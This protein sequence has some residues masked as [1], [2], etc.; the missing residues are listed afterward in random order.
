MKIA[1]VVGV[2]HGLFIA[3]GIVFAKPGSLASAVLAALVA[4]EVL[5]LVLLVLWGSIS[6]ASNTP[7]ITIGLI[8][9]LGSNLATVFLLLSL[10][11]LI[12]TAAIAFGVVKGQGLIK[13]LKQEP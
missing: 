3:M 8:K 11:F 10:I 6:L 7:Q 2:V 4:T 5:L 13:A 12:P 9:T 1:L